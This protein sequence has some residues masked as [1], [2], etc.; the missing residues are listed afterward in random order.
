MVKLYRLITQGPVGRD[1][2]TRLHQLL[3]FLP[4]PDSL[5]FKFNLALSEPIDV[6]SDWID[7]VEAA[8]APNAQQPDYE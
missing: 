7:A 2:C 8:N 5:F 6:Y 3:C 4:D 1:R